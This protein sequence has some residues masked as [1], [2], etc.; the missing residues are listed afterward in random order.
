LLNRCDHCTIAG[1]MNYPYAAWRRIL[2]VAVLVVI[3]VIAFAPATTQGT[4]FLRFSSLSSP[5]IV[6]HVYV[7]F[8]QVSL[9][10]AGY[11]NSSGWVIITQ[12]FPNIDLLSNQAIPLTVTSA[13]IHSGRYDEIRVTF[14]NSTLVIAGQRTPM[15]A[16]SVLSANVTLPVS[17]SGIGDI[18]LVVAF[19]YS[20]LF[21]SQ[22][23]LSFVLIRAS[24]V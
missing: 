23:S 2:F 21:S 6:S 11:L 10:Q 12:S 17:P 18:L 4:L 19:D 1:R 22:P 15:S 24:T 14:S 3:I 8:T 9:H 5:S 13:P 20:A 7:G 16:P